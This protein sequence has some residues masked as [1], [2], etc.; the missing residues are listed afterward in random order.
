MVVKPGKKSKTTIPADVQLHVSTVRIPSLPPIGFVGLPAARL[1]RAQRQRRVRLSG[2]CA[3]A[4]L[5]AVFS[6]A[7]CARNLTARP[8]RLPPS[9]GI[10]GRGGQGRPL[11]V[12]G[13]A[14]RG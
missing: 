11:R 5:R 6:H 10:T 2:Q 3:C 1:A 9:T 14:G 8:R 12:D 7:R 13:A 4:L